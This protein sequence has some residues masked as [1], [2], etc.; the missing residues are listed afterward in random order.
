MPEFPSWP[1]EV[2]NAR[3]VTVSDVLVRIRDVLN[4][5]VSPMETAV[6]G[7][8]SEYFR[9]RTRADPREFAQG[10]KRMDFLGPNVFFLGLSRAYDGQDR[11]DVHFSSSA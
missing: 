6:S 7:I 4:R 8:A 11:W 9:A 3:G 5:S 10:V 1:I 2:V